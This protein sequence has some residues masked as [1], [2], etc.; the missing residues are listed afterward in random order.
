MTFSEFSNITA[1]GLNVQ[2]ICT[3]LTMPSV[4]YDWHCSLICKCNVTQCRYV[5]CVLGVGL[6]S[7]WNIAIIFF[8]LT[9]PEVKEACENGMWHDN[10]D[11]VGNGKWD[12]K[13]SST[14]FQSDNY[15]FSNWT[16]FCDIVVAW[17]T[18][19]HVFVTSMVLIVR[20]W[21]SFL[22]LSAL[23]GQHRYT[24]TTNWIQ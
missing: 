14:I 21:C 1:L 8:S 20:F 3:V 16:F 23:R 5:C 7:E 9:R 13:E 10:S 24:T 4:T 11:N 6:T 19:W 22:Y 18:V 17:H 12:V 15:T 2:W